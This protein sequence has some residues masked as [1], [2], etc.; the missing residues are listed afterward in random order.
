M[1]QTRAIGDHE[2][3]RERDGEPKREFHKGEGQK[4]SETGQEMRGGGDS[5]AVNIAYQRR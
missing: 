3:K 5:G 1:K 4:G 2:A